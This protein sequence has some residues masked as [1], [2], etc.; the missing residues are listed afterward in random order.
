MLLFYSNNIKRNE[1][2]E[3]ILYLVSNLIGG[4]SNSRRK[5][6]TSKIYEEILMII[7]EENLYNIY[8]ICLETF[9]N[10]YR[11][12]NQ[13]EISQN[14]LSNERINETS[15]IMNLLIIHLSDKILLLK[16]LE[17]LVELTQKLPQD[18]RVFINKEFIERLFYLNN[19]IKRS[20]CFKI[21]GNLVSY[22]NLA[23]Y[24]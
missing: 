24:V 8:L 7:K 4:N 20:Y 1:F 13:E 15:K 14:L 21:L 12:N 9:V 23:I 17:C 10:I 3:N 2:K 22:G 11:K 6:L 16:I 18:N 5:I 19:I